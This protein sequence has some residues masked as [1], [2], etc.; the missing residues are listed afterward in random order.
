MS[1]LNADT[2]LMPESVTPKALARALATLFQVQL[3]PEYRATVT[4]VDSFD[5]RLY[6][7]D[8]LLHT[9]SGSWTLYE[10]SG[11]IT[12]L[13]GGPQCRTR[14]LL[15]DFPEGGMKERLAPVLGIRALLPLAQVRLQ[16][17]QWHLHDRE[18]RLVLRLVLEEQALE[19]QTFRLARL[20]PVQEQDQALDQAQGILRQQ[21]VVQPVSP[22]IGFEAGCRAAGREPL[23][24]CAK[25]PPALSRALRELSASEALICIWRHLLGQIRRNMPGVLEDLDPL[26]LRDFRV[27]VRRTRT[28]LG[29]GKRVFPQESLTHFKEGFAAL[30]RLAGPARDL[31][32]FLQ[33]EARFL[34]HLP[35]RMRPSLQAAFAELARERNRVRRSLLR[36]LHSRQCEQLLLDWEHFLD[37]GG[38][39]G[40][41]AASQ[42]AQDLADR[43]LGKLGRKV[44]AY[45]QVSAEMPDSELH[46]LRIACKKLRYTLEF[47]R[48]LYPKEETERVIQGLK[49]VQSALGHLHDASVQEQLIQDCLARLQASPDS[50]QALAIAGLQALCPCLREERALA[51]ERCGGEWVNFVAQ[52][53]AFALLLAGKKS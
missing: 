38:M 46:S 42:P 25:F 24:Y 7:A 49:A 16:G 39:A 2:W 1:S 28:A 22:L 52:F 40:R 30:G 51:L 6:Q 36:F 27:S 37:Q 45:G 10:P 12:L 8:M 13:R 33:A 53:Q 9:H 26:F 18:G 3:L 35:S 31:D 17:C 23:D 34:E 29:M 20:F 11:Q 21:G 15:E 41:K 44:L 19:G 48:A 50:S 4:Y 43:M 5:W 47:F 14:C 32:A